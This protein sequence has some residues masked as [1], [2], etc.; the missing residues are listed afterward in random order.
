MTLIKVFHLFLCFVITELI[1]FYPVLIK[2][3]VLSLYV[4]Y[5]RFSL[6]YNCAPACV[7]RAKIK[8][9]ESDFNTGHLNLS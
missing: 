4:K 7:I 9:L 6:L 5:R 2:T 3:L 1:L 8:V